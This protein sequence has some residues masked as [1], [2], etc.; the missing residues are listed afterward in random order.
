MAASQEDWIKHRA[1]QLWEQEG[2]PSGKD[3]EH[4]ERAKLEYAALKPIASEKSAKEPAKAKAAPKK[5]PAKAKTAAEKTA[6]PKTK[7]KA[8]AEVPKTKLA[9]AAAKPETKKSAAKPT[10]H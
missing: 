10:T 9:A 3:T 1:Y 7:A 8:K 4:W 5:A 2:Y 6:T